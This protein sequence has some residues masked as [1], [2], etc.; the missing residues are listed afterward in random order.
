MTASQIDFPCHRP[1]AGAMSSPP[2]LDR[3]ERL[4]RWALGAFDALAMAVAVVSAMAPD[5]G[6][7]RSRAPASRSWRSRPW[8]TAAN[9]VRAAGAR[10]LHHPASEAAWRHGEA[11]GGEQPM[12]SAAQT[13]QQPSKQTATSKEKPKPA[14]AATP[15]RRTEKPTPPAAAAQARRP[16]PP[17][18]ARAPKPVPANGNGSAPMPDLKA[19]GIDGGD[20]QAHISRCED[21]GRAYRHV[22]K[23]PKDAM[24]LQSF[25]RKL[26][27]C[28]AGDQAHAP[29]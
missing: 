1:S 22:M 6:C 5:G 29:A 19:F 23:N 15:A 10:T 3:V 24:A 18:V 21:C 14:R 26:A 27:A 7:V 17:V 11:D 25:G 20:A 13:K 9:D 16:T 4:G 12:K 8:A 2:S 28:A